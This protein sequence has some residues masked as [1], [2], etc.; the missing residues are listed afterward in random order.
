M[1]KLIRVAFMFC[2]FLGV[3]FLGAKIYNKSTKMDL[4]DATEKKKAQVAEKIIDLKRE[5]IKKKLAMEKILDGVKG[6]LHKDEKSQKS[7]QVKK[8]VEQ[9]VTPTLPAQVLP[10]T[11]VALNP[12]DDEDRKLTAEVLDGFQGDK[13]T[14]KEAVK[15]DE[16]E[17]VS[18]IPQN[19]FPEEEP[20]EPVDLNRL[21]EIR[22]LYLKASETL[23]WK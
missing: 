20:E 15:N 23:N 8:E 16:K 9:E 1:F 3:I 22:E 4:V 7:L 6:S 5:V 10:K 17:I 21:T 11:A 14:S 2:L 12:L 18:T 13:L 19:V